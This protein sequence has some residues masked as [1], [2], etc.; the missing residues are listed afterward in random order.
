MKATAE[1]MDDYVLA[2]FAPTARVFQFHEDECQLPEGA[3]LLFEGANVRVQAFRVV[4]IDFA[5]VATN[6]IQ[7]DR[8]LAHQQRAVLS[9]SRQK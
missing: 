9:N 5:P 1:G 8:A 2:P 3:Q 7:V 4:T 6:T